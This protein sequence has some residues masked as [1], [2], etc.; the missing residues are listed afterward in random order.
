MFR[1]DRDGF[2]DPLMKHEHALPYVLQRQDLPPVYCYNCVLDV[3]RPSTILRKE[4]MTGDRILAYIL[5]ED[6]VMD[7][8]TRRDLEIARFLME[9]SR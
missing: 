5:P 3:T 1:I 4:S 8:D 6:E 7:I 2:L 9:R